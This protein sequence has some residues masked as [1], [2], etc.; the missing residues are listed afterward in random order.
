MDTSSGG[1]GAGQKNNKRSKRTPLAFG[2]RYDKLLGAFRR[3]GQQAGAPVVSMVGV[4]IMSDVLLA[5]AMH[6]YFEETV[7]NGSVSFLR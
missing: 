1:G 7:R 4:T 3:P 5:A 6:A 2:G